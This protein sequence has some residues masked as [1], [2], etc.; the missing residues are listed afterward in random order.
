M[1]TSMLLQNPKGRLYSVKCMNEFQE[2]PTHHVNPLRKIDPLTACRIK[3][4]SSCDVSD[5]KSLSSTSL[6]VPGIKRN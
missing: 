4:L 6:S 3:V 2:V 1:Q 5:R